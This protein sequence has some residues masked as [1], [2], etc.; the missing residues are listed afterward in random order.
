[1][2]KYFLLLSVLTLQMAVSAQTVNVHLK[3]G[4]SVNYPAENV[5]FVDFSDK[6]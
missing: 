2:K 5:D 4:Q 6:P 1:M 3:N